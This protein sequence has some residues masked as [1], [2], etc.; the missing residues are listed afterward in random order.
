MIDSPTAEPIEY[1]PPTQSQNSNMLPASMPKLTTSALLVETATKC[2]DIAASSPIA[3]K[4]HWRAARALVNVSRV[5]NVFEQTM[6]R[7]SS[8]STARTASVKSV[9]STLET[10]RK[11]MS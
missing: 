8:G 3:F 7:V 5:V 2:F 4:H 10:K 1:R 11:V 6:N 9:P